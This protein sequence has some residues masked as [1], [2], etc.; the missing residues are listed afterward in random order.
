MYSVVGSPGG[1]WG[2]RLVRRTPVALLGSVALLAVA[3]SSGDDAATSNRSTTTA[4][5]SAPTEASDSTQ[6]TTSTSTTA[7]PAAY[8]P[9]YSKG[10]CPVPVQPDL[11]IECGTVTVP[12]D[13]ADPMGSQVELAVARVSSPSA[14]GAE[15]PVVRLSGGPGGSALRDLDVPE[16][17]GGVASDPLLAE[18]DLVFVDQRGTGATRPSLDC[19]ERDEAVWTALASDAPFAEELEIVHESLRTCRDRLESEGIDLSQYDSVASATDIDDVRQAMSIDRWTLRATSYGT[20]LA[21]QMMRAHPDGVASVILDSV[22]PVDTSSV[23][24]WN[25]SPDRAFDTLFTGCE[26]S[27]E[28]HAAYPELRE[29]FTAMLTSFDQ[30]PMEA[31]VT[32]PT[33]TPRSISID[34][35]VVLAGVFNLMYS[36]KQLPN[37]PALIGLMES[38]NP[39]VQTGFEQGFWGLFGLSEG[40]HYVV[41]CRDRWNGVTTEDVNAAMDERPTLAFL[42]LVIS[43]AGCEALDAGSVDESFGQPVRSDI[44]T[45]VLAGSYD[46]VTPPEGGARVAE[47]LGNATFVEFDGT[48]HGVHRANR[49]VEGLVTAFVDD[50][51]APLDTSCVEAVGPPEFATG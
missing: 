43:H 10:E 36:T 13:R 17:A 45:L 28:C 21:Q 42:T 18:H 6:A 11:T 31:T 1:W 15:N 32:D 9:L 35:S 33:G 27:P 23:D 50:P 19:P 38:R 25:E 39:A 29:R 37:L 48:G 46:P 4:V 5:V 8:T 16:D 22:V 51:T 34:D 7:M 44:P 14:T 41:D 2:R 30:D 20:V 26:A 12:E 24:R 47:H 49:C 3:C 40:A